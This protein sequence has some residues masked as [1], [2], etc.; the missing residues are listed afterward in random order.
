MLPFGLVQLQI[1]YLA[2][3]LP[4]ARQ[5][6]YEDVVRVVSLSTSAR[7]PQVH[8]ERNEPV[9]RL[10]RACHQVSAVF[11][12][13]SEGPLREPGVAL[14]LLL[15][16]RPRPSVRY[17]LS[18]TVVICRRLLAGLRGR[19]PG[20]GGCPSLERCSATNKTG[21]MLRSMRWAVFSGLV[22]DLIMIIPNTIRQMGFVDLL[23]L[24]RWRPY[25]G[26]I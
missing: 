15:L 17:K 18:L 4:D 24:V 12:V 3:I 2:R 1:S 25:P 9:E 14:P 16:R 20:A 13:G 8:D 11:V 21:E 23:C 26:V 6:F 10:H 5:T 19:L 22:Y 7:I